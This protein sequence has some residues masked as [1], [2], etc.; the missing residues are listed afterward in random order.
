MPRV[1]R[2]P[3]WSDDQYRWA[4]LAEACGQAACSVMR[5]LEQREQEA[6]G[7]AATGRWTAGEAGYVGG[8]PNRIVTVNEIR[9]EFAYQASLPIV[10]ATMAARCALEATG[11]L[12]PRPTLRF[13]SDFDTLIWVRVRRLD[14]R[15]RNRKQPRF[16][17]SWVEWFTRQRGVAWNHVSAVTEVDPEALQTIAA[18]YPPKKSPYHGRIVYRS[19]GDS[20]IGRTEH[21]PLHGSA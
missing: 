9:E 11:R 4:L 3:G 5:K 17:E 16:A 10:H 18:E 15:E 12:H 1:K 8:N 6:L 2:F 13:N 7:R 14:E 20:K 21:R 19:R